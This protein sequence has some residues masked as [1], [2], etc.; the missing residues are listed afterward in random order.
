[1]YIEK[2]SHYDPLSNL[3]FWETVD[4]YSYYN[5]FDYVFSEIENIIKALNLLLS[6][7]YKYLTDEEY[8]NVINQ[9]Y[10]I[11]F[12]KNDILKILST[13]DKVNYNKYQW[14]KTRVIFTTL[15]SEGHGRD[16]SWWHET[17]QLMLELITPEDLVIDKKHDYSSE[18]I[19]EIFNNYKVYLFDFSNKELGIDPKLPF[20][21]ETSIGIKIPMFKLVDYDEE[22]YSGFELGQ[23]K[24]EDEKFNE[25]IKQTGY[26]LVRKKIRP[27]TV[28]KFAKDIFESIYNHINYYEDEILKCSFIKEK[29]KEELIQRI[30]KIINQMGVE[31]SIITLNQQQQSGPV[32]AK[33][34]KPQKN[35][36]NK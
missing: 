35:T 10:S 24:Y 30:K 3:P 17:R 36:G 31:N 13:I 4:R 1:M 26:K 34:N 29:E 6:K 22:D 8:Y 9:F 23:I 14:L 19:K 2:K 32:L 7:D 18:E 5:E 33:K 12:F 15:D 16:F 11:T 25:N 28:F 20:V 21:K 27:T